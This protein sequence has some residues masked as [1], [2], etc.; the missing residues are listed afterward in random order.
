MADELEIAPGLTI[1][2]DLVEIRTSRSSG[3][4]GQ[5]ANVTASRV[6]AVLDLDAVEN[7]S[8]AQRARLMAKLGRRVSATAQDT[9]SQA[10]N[11]DLA[12]GRLAAKLRAGLVQQAPRRPS[13]PSRGSVERRLESKRRQSAR[14]H[15]RRPPPDA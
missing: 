12:L 1:P 7:L 5:H 9:R 14:K 4:G 8:D 13:R 11:R 2:L 6:E 10:R 3:P 15:N